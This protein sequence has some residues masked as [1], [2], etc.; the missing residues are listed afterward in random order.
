MANGLTATT[1]FIV[2]K[3]DRNMVDSVTKAIFERAAA[4]AVKTPEPS[5][6]A[7]TNSNPSVNMDV[8]KT[9]IQND[10]MT[11]A[12]K[13]LT[14][15]VNPFAEGIFK[16]QAT[17]AAASTNAT[18]AQAGVKALSSNAAIKAP[19]VRVT[20]SMAL[21]N[22]MFTSAIR[23]SMMIQAKEQIVNNTDL[24]S[25]LQFLNSKTAVNLYPAKQF[26]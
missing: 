26:N 10:V 14:Q 3:I 9:S 21:Q 12:R 11:E 19:R 2:Q 17:Q 24:M 25:R 5:V 7:K 22:G 4:K 16:S 18:E 20:E 8:Y 6:A 13:S 15:S 23:E 1:N